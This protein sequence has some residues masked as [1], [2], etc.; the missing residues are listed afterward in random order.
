MKFLNKNYFFILLTLKLFNNY[1][2]QQKKKYLTDSREKGID[3][4]C[5]W[6][7]KKVVFSKNHVEHKFQDMKL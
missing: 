1:S 3:M 6:L 4:F 2:E 7:N 5:L